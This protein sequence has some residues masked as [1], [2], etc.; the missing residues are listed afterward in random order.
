[1]MKA[2]ISI[3]VLALGGCVPSMSTGPEPHSIPYEAST[4]NKVSNYLA[5]HPDYMGFVL[6]SAPAFP[7]DVRD[8]MD[9]MGFESYQRKG[10]YQMY[11]CGSGV[12]GKGWGFVH[13]PF[14]Q[15]EVND[16][17]LIP[18]ESFSY[19]AQLDSNWYRFAVR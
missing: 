19:I 2:G 10:D 3:L 16:P 1:M 9:D 8:A 7:S 6:E 4:F 14:S 12:V 13:G 18:F 17:A 11:F 15:E 5:Q